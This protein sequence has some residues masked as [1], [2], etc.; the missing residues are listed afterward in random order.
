MTEF[1]EKLRF[2][3]LRSNLRQKEL[4]SKTGLRA[5]TISDLEA[6]KSTPRRRT[7]ALLARALG[8]TLE[9]FDAVA[10][11]ISESEVSSNGHSKNGGAEHAVRVLQR[12]ADGEVPPAA[13]QRALGERPAIIWITDRDLRVTTTCRTPASGD[14]PDQG[15]TMVPMPVDRWCVEQFG[16]SA[17]SPLPADAHAWALRGETVSYT[18][19]QRGRR[20]TVHLRSRR[21]RDGAIA[22]V[23]G[24]ALAATATT[25]PAPVVTTLAMPLVS[26]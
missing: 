16:E 26:C 6:G 1:G 25:R 23:I 24:V 21:G 4:A 9:A 10:V 11:T 18:S 19:T 13:L 20:W 14:A 2:L 22:G 5:S 3:R 8:M 15:R 12:V 17:S 7:R